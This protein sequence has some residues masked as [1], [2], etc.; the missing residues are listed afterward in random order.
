MAYWQMLNFGPCVAAPNLWFESSL[1]KINLKISY[2][3]IPPGSKILQGISNFKDGNPPSHD[4][5]RPLVI[6]GDDFS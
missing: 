1:N 3:E 5:M 6:N 2:A 4:L